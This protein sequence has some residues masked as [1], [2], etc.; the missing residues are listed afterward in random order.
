MNSFEENVSI[1]DMRK[2]KIGEAKIKF[3]ISMYKK[4]ELYLYPT[5]KVV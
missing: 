3:D 2:Q 1:I 5:E 4:E